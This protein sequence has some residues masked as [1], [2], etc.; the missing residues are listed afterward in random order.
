MKI[1]CIYA[2]IIKS[3]LKKIFNLVEAVAFWVPGPA[4]NLKLNFRIKK[5]FGFTHIL[6]PMNPTIY[7]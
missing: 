2:I 7:W 1:V 5:M 3:I 4:Q 6:D